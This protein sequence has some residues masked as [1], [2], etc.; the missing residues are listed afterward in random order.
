M[1]RLVLVSLFASSTALAQPL[2]VETP[3][4]PPV[5][6]SLL[7]NLFATTLGTSAEVRFDYSNLDGIDVAVLNVL[8]HVQYLTPQGF[9]GYARLP[10]A[11]V[12]D[13]DD[14]IDFGGSGIGNLEVGGLYVVKLA[15]NTDL[16][17]RGG[18]SIDTASEDDQLAITLSTILPRLIDTYATG[19]ETTWARGQVQIRHAIDNIRIGGAIGMDVPVAGDGADED[20]LVGMVNGVVAVGLQQGQLGLGLSLAMLQPI[21]DEDDENLMGLNVGADYAI[22]PNVRLFAQIGVSLEDN[23]DGTAAGVGGRSTF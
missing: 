3:P 1:K 8:V 2:E 12:E 11:Y 23:A 13:S 10:F 16:L 9:G 20:G 4:A 21:S 14:G 19:L 5:V 22:N 7:P 18:V 6:Q 15:P 17:A